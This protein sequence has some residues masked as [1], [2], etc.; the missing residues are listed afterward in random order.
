MELINHRTF[1]H[2]ILTGAHQIISKEKELNKINVFPVADGDTGSNLAY[3]MK[4]IVRETKW[5]EP[6]TEMLNKMKTACLRGSRGNSGMIFSQF[7]ISMCDFLSKHN[8]IK[9]EQFIEMCEY[10]VARSYY[11]VNEPQEGTVLTVMKDW[12]NVMKDNSSQSTGILDVMQDSFSEVCVSLENTKNQLPVLQ[13]HN[14][15]DAGAKGFVHFLQGLIDSMKTG[16][17]LNITK[18][19]VTTE[20]SSLENL[21]M[22]SMVVDNHTFSDTDTIVNRY[23]SEFLFDVTTN[24]TEIRQ[25]LS[26]LGDSFIVV[27]D[28]NQGKVHIHTNTPERVAEVINENGSII[29]QKVEDMQRQHET[30]Y[31]RK[32]S[33]AIVVDSACDI[34]QDLLD[35]YQIHM[36]PLHLQL[37]NSTYLDKV[38][39]K[40][41]TFYNKLEKVT[42][43]PKTSQPT[44][45]SITNLYTQLLN[46]YDHI[47]SIHLSK[48]LSG[49]YE[50]CRSAAEQI[51]S[52]R[53]HVVNSRTLSGAYGLLVQKTAQ[54]I[55]QGNSFDEIKTAL[56]TWIP[57]SEILVSVP[58][59]KHMI[60][61]GRVS[62]LQ[63]KIA[64]WL[65]MKPIVSIDREGKSLLYGKTFFK[66]SSL[67]KLLQF[68]QKINAMNKIESYA[69]LHADSIQDSS[70]CE[71]EM[72][73]ITGQKP[74][75]VT[76][77]SAVIGLNA[78]KGAVS[79]A[80]LLSDANQRGN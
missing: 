55:E 16:T 69:I 21:T 26:S 30:L 4:M 79:V 11:S 52:A 70:L 54:S 63:G 19:D 45:E 56:S 5:I 7:I 77:V 80:M 38:T 41:E 78:G 14:V 10:S 68:T 72:I 73:R 60:R 71:R 42:E 18:D 20:L 29:Y 27:G 3:L 44:Q 51:D 13:Q 48:E 74:K 59:L 24:L 33:I 9:T 53:V 15:V 67:E 25:Q 64:R 23:C 35:K 1:Y 61:G 32:S 2:M 47:I 8:E 39:L 62:P 49:T 75:Y 50:A 65:D 37:G 28:Q 36:L 34:P 40:S 22:Y 76:S 57:T 6:S 46:H 17:H 58:T 43:Q 66:R 12:I 31:Q